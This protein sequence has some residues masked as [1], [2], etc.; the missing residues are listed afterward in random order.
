[1]I[2]KLSIKM[3]ERYQSA[4]GSRRFFNL[5]CNF[6]PSCSQYTK[7]CIVKYGAYKG[8]RLAF[9]RI[10]RCDDPQQVGKIVDPVP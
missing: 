9:S 3:I 7:L 5:E 1:M 4:G 8:W 6:E 10:K 2:A